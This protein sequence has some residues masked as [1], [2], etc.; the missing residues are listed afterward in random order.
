MSIMGQL[1]V[2]ITLSAFQARVYFAV[3]RHGPINPTK[4][5]HHLGFEYDV[6]SPSVSR[7]LKTLLKCGLI[8]KTSQNKR[9]VNYH[10]VDSQTPP[11]I[12]EGAVEE[13]VT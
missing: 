1:I 13:D 6:A 2:P 10:V 11:L 8:T 7:P 3:K 4:L 12:I 9:V 5:G